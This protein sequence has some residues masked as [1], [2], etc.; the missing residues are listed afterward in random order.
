MDKIIYINEETEIHLFKGIDNPLIALRSGDKYHEKIS[1]MIPQDREHEEV[2]VV[3][4]E[5]CLRIHRI[6]DAFPGYEEY[7]N[8]N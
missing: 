8:A 1:A 2:I 5:Y 4:C 3:I 7:W 6:D